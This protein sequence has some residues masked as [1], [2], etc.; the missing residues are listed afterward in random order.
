MIAVNFFENSCSLHHHMPH[1][2]QKNVDFSFEASQNVN[3]LGGFSP[4]VFVYIYISKVLFDS[5]Y[6]YRS[7][8]IVE[9]PYHVVL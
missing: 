8:E 9:K 2:G 3:F 5:I 1:W 6:F 7:M 4:T